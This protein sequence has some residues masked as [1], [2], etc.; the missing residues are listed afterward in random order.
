MQYGHDSTKKEKNTLRVSLANIGG[1]PTSADDEKNGAIWQFVN[2]NNID[3]TLWTE[4]DKHWQSLAFKDRLPTR[5][6]FE[7]LHMTT[8]YYK[9]Y[10]GATKQQYGGVSRWSTGQAAHRIKDSGIDLATG[11]DR[12]GLGWWA[13]TQYAGRN[14]VSLRV[15][16]AYC[17]V[18]NKCCP[19][20]VWN[21]QKVYWQSHNVDTDPI[22]KFT[23]DPAAEVAV[24]LASGD[25]VVLGLDV[26]E[27]IRDGMFQWAME[28]MGLVGLNTKQHGLD[29]PPT[30]ID[31]SL[32][33]DE[34]F[35]S[36]GLDSLRCGYFSMQFDHRS[37]WVD[38]P[39]CLAFGC[40]V[41][42]IVHPQACCLKVGDPR[43]VK[44]YVELYDVYLLKHDL[45][46][47][48]VSL[49]AAGVGDMS[50]GT[51]YNEMDAVR[52]LGMKYVEQNCR[53]LQ[54][55]QVDWTPEWQQN[56]LALSF[57]NL[58]LRK[59]DRHKIKSKT[60]KQAA[61]AAGLMEFLDATVEVAKVYRTLIYQE[62]KTMCAHS[63]RAHC[64]MWL[65][66]LAEAKALAGNT[67]AETVLKQLMEREQQHHDSRAIRYANQK[68]RTGSVTFLVA[69]NSQG[70]W[71]EV[72]DQ[73][74]MEQAL[75]EENHRHFNQA[76]G[77]PFTLPPL[78]D[79]ID[80][81]GVNDYAKQILAGT[82]EIPDGTNYY[83]AKLIPLLRCPSLV[84]DGRGSDLNLT[85]AK[86]KKG[87]QQC[88]ESTSSG[89]SGLHFGHFMAG[90]MH[91]RVTT[92]EATMINFP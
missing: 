45:Y 32:P 55:G 90:S 75:M 64:Q 56:T 42:P 84:V 38:I 57:W 35:V 46:K 52:C 72:N 19:M 92:F 18:L 89:P 91:E 28:H 87:W 31:G 37:L 88:R 36:P 34:L 14:G 63:N 78:T 69:P 16:V 80:V 21:Q 8:A 17:P 61:S 43:I 39:Y 79:Y 13:W 24:W 30:Y 68:M 1:F 49:E 11:K 54:C 82:F 12:S 86:H 5:R 74:S 23:N 51:L 66:S 50:L 6:W 48:V 44:K 58:R 47:K 71:V 59:L 73:A 3:V 26:N 60:L 70:E 9:S 27:D 65:H 29:G 76:A 53:K 77:T 25:Q 67:K 41:P 10:P 33:I 81:L 22:V 85:I 2:E 15:V 40:D 7:S 62:R 20:S 83:A 4:T